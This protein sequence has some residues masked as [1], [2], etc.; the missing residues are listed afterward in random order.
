MA[1]SRA[2]KRLKRLHPDAH[3]QRFE[4]WSGVGVFDSNACRRGVEI[5]VENK[6]VRDVKNRHDDWILK[7]KV[8]RSQVAW[9]AERQKR[10][11]R[12]FV[13]IVVGKDLFVL[14]GRFLAILGQG[15]PYWQLLTNQLDPKEIFH[16]TG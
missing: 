3:W 14:P 10:G 13:A 12:T 16:V 15:M 9:Q 1:E 5:W 11:A 2:Y 7:A 6:E 8:R 4:S